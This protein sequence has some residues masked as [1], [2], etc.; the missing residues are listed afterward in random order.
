MMKIE[1]DFEEERVGAV[2]TFNQNTGML[3]LTLLTFLTFLSLP[4]ST[5][6]TMVPELLHQ[7]KQVLVKGGT[8]GKGW[9]SDAGTSPRG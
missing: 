9:I 8:V 5:L 4:T 2:L 6:Q 1:T 3:E 7:V